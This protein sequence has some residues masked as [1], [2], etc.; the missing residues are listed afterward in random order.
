[1]QQV[2]LSSG[3]AVGAFVVEMT[4]VAHQGSSTFTI[5]DFSPA[6]IVVSVISA[7]SV[8]FFYRLPSDAGSEVSGHR[9][10]EIASRK[11]AARAAEKQV[12]EATVEVRD[13]KL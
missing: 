11:G 12:V 6:F 13:R 9:V 3:V 2:A 7:A 5:S 10:A 8:V 4:R 1:M